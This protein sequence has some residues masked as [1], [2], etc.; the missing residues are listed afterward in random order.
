MA[1]LLSPPLP[2]D[3]SYPHRGMHVCVIRVYSAQRCVCVCVMCVMWCVGQCVCVRVTGV[4]SCVFGC[5]QREFKQT[6]RLCA[7][8]SCA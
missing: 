2:S 6:A 4:P 5:R 8:R 7:V 3:C 1:G